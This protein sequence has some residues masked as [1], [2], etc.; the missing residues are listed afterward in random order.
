MDL[1]RENE[2]FI[3]WVNRVVPQK[4]KSES[5]LSWTV[6]A[7]PENVLKLVATFRAAA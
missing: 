5:W 7:I 1:M 2:T 6:R 3:E 4:R